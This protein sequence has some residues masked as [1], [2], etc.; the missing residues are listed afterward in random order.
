MKTAY[1]DMDGVLTDFVAGALAA[2]DKTLPPDQVAWDFN[3]QIGLTAE[4][5]WRPLGYVFWAELGWT[6]EGKD[7]LASIERLFGDNVIIVSTPSK[8]IGSA[9]GKIAWLEQHLPRYARK[10]AL[11]PPKYMLAH[12]NAILI[13]DSDANVQNFVARGKALLIP[14]PWNRRRAEVDSLGRFNVLQ[15]YAELKELA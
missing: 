6:H 9:D 3:E 2:H 1:V 12:P 8:G 14:R 15:M 10:Y 4:E 5:F 7:L 11:C 13:D